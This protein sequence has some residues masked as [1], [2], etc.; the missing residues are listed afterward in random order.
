MKR[1]YLA[2]AARFAFALS[3]VACALV[4]GCIMQQ[5][6]KD[7]SQKQ[8]A[9]FVETAS[10]AMGPLS[11]SIAFV[12]FIEPRLA[13]NAHFLLPGRIEGCRVKEG[14][15][16]KQGEEIC[17]LDMS[18]VNLEVARAENSV[19]AA[20]KV[21]ETNLP[22]KQK[23]L[24]E[25]GMIGQAEFE[26]VRVQAEGAKAQYSDASSLFE[27]AQKK[28]G[29]HYLLAPWDGVVTRLLV[30]PGQPIVP[31]MPVA[32]LS[33]ERSFQIGIDMHAA[34]FS[35]LSVGSKGR[36]LTVSSRAIE[37]PTSLVVVEKS[38]AVNPET[39]SFHLV[40]RP[41]VGSDNAFVPGVLVTGELQ[42]IS[43]ESA[44]HIPQRSL[45]SWDQNGSA[46]V[47]V[48]EQGKL[49]VRKVR[50]GIFAGRDVQIL[51]GLSS[52]ALVVVEPAPDHVE[53][54][55]VRVH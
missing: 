11:E 3:S 42:T 33:D 18:A 12:G 25:A 13:V 14:D 22:A 43:V 51:D 5:A 7:L 6:A 35:R 39:Q 38:I 49:V 44:I 8:A 23:A 24:F 53:G 26:Q 54:M 36:L 19:S 10:P 40:V 16:V 45:V 41:E 50:T 29:E 30:K 37:T 1:I 15:I 52:D 46:T 21:M 47:F 9:R 34:Y 32:I 20:K 2:V 17:H 28:K 31:E 4:S 48:V 55:A 27:M